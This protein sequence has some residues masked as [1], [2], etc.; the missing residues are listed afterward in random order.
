MEE[1]LD[2]ISP[3]LPIDFFSIELDLHP[4]EWKKPLKKKH[5][6]PDFS[7]LLFEDLFAHVSMGWHEKALFFEIDVKK[8]FEECFFPE[9]RKG[10]SVELFIDTRAMKNAGFLTRFCHHF[11]FLPKPIDDVV[12]QEITSF[13][14]DDRHELCNG[15]KLQCKATFKSRSY[16]LE[17]SLPLECL[18]G[19][20]PSSFDRL[21]FTYRI[22][23]PSKDPQHFAVSSEY[24]A[25]ENQPSL[26]STMHMRKK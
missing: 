22:N 21:G 25:I 2:Q 6:L 13:R 4:A 12:A 8:P 24:L 16:F 11:V 9:F 15:E 5:I 7:E 20:D 17:I 10:D 18:H 1:N 19:Y 26:W 3:I 23:R 14:T